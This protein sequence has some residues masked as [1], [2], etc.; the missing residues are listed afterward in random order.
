VRPFETPRPERG[1]LPLLDRAQA[2][3]YM[4]EVR[5]R[6]RAIL[7]RR[8]TGDGVLHEMVLRHELQHGETML[9]AIELGRLLPA[10]DVP[11]L[12]RPAA[13]GGYTGL[14]AVEV[15][16]GPCTLGPRTA[17]SPTTTS[18]RATAWTC[19]RS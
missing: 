14:E 17:A 19:R 15:P 11:R 12:P 7:E 16:A 18:A 13:P 8:G 2:L 3:E 9:Q 1:D 5:E 10:P 6:V 4:G